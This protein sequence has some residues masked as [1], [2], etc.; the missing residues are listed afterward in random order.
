MTFIRTLRYRIVASFVVFGLILSVALMGGAYFAFSGIEN[1]VLQDAMRAEISRAQLYQDRSTDTQTELPAMRLYA[2]ARDEPGKLPGY[3]QS[4]APG[5]YRL[6]EKGRNLVVRVED[7]GKERYVVSY[8]ETQLLKRSQFWMLALTGGILAALGVSWLTG[9]ALAGQLIQPVTQLT[10]DVRALEAGTAS[11]V[12]LQRYAD[13]EVG[14]LAQAFQAYRDRFKDLVN[15]EQ[16][17]AS[18]VSHELRTPVTSIN[19]AVEVL[20]GDVTLSEQ[21]RY[22]LQRIRRAGREMSELINTFL[23]LSRHEGGEELMD[24]DVNRAVREIVDDQQ[25]WIGDKPV[26]T[27]IIEDA[28]LTVRAPRGVVSVLIGNVVRNAYRY[29]KS[30]LVTVRIMA[31]RV[32]V[33]DTGPGIERETLARLFDRHVHGASVD[34]GTGLGLSIVKRLCE[35]YGWCV[36]FASSI[37]A[38]S[39]FDLVFHVNS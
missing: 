21:Q 20:S 32:A 1:Y 22:R 25:V 24:C 27:R 26:S 3:L 19:L 37:G 36:E 8:D 7:R 15:R 29:T 11:R 13:D 12:E 33:E 18:N 16:E 34:H 5:D 9:Y 38:G 6:V 10:A 28:Q 17:F 2:R 30:G 31:D 23:L 39:R 14:Q 35:R 4:L